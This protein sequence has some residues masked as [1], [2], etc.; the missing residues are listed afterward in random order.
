MARGAR[1]VGGS[2]KLIGTLGESFSAAWTPD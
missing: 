2:L 1:P